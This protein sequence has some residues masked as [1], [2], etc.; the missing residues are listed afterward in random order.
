MKRLCCFLFVLVTLASSFLALD[1]ETVATIGTDTTYNSAT[2]APTPYGTYFRNFRLQYLYTASEIQAAG[3][4]LGNIT[5]LAFNVHSINDCSSMP[6]YTIRIKQTNLS[7]FSAAPFETGTYE[8]VFYQDNFLP[9]P[10]WNEHIFDAP[11]EWDG[12]SNIIIDIV[13]TL[14]PTAYTENASAYY[15]QTATNTALSYYSDTIDAGSY[16]GNGDT[17]RNRANIRFTIVP[18]TVEDPP[19]SAT[20]ISPSLDSTQ[21]IYDT[22]FRWESGGGFPTAYRI[23]LGT[24]GNGD[25]RPSDVLNGLDVGLS[26][27]H[28]HAEGLA[29]NTD[30]Y[31]QIVPYND[32]G[33]AQNCPIWHFQTAHVIS[34]ADFETWPPPGWDLTGGSSGFSA[35][36]DDSENTWAEASFFNDPD[37]TTYHLTSPPLQ[38]LYPA[39]LSFKWSHQLYPE[40]PD[41]AL[42]IQISNDTIDW[43][44]LWYKTGNDFVSDD[45]GDWIS[46]GTGITESINLPPAITSDGFYIRFQALSGYGADLFIDNVLISTLVNQ[47]SGDGSNTAPY[48]IASLSDLRWLSQTPSAWDSFF[49]QTADIDAQATESWDAG[50]GFSPI[51]ISEAQCFTGTYN[52]NGYSISNLYINRPDTDIIALFG[53]TEGA[54]ISNLQL[55]LCN[56]PLQV[57]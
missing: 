44:E 52:G 40:Y 39:T 30:Y 1:A 55:E 23:Y 2:T 32:N 17:S 28:H 19:N 26:H 27:S 16:T 20:L 51:G 57:V 9:T 54:Y 53:Y 41:D 34:S 22:E 10:G 6:D 43:T 3:G 11:Y 42:S 49:S 35:Y 29:E 15:S 33:D 48:Q 8:Q 14:L 56:V 12:V 5:K 47:P 36:T 38:S 18:E 13:C 31:W 24:D 7:A 37:G 46:A 25:T 50:A 4:A 21:A 45:G